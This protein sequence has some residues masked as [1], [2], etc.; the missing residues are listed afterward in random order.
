M[1]K[2]LHECNDSFTLLDLDLRVLNRPY[3]LIEEAAEETLQALVYLLQISCEEVLVRV[4][5]VEEFP[6]H[7]SKDA[8][9]LPVVSC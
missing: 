5:N 1:W 4:F 3:L 2:S 8:D 7:G 6:V 9:A